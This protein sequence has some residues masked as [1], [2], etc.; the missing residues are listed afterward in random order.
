MPTNQL[1]FA[2]TKVL[3]KQIKKILTTAIKNGGTTL[4][5][6]F[7]TS[8][9]PGYFSQKLQVYGRDKQ[10]CYTCNTVIEAINLGQRNTFYCP[11]C[12]TC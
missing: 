12:Q 7:N 5:D 1:T 4:R 6:F 2:Q 11:K 8:G 3:T 9:K 10:S